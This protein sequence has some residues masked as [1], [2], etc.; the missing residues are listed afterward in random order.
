M[1]RAVCTQCGNRFV[2]R[3]DQDWKVLCLSCWKARA[4]SGQ[5][6][7]SPLLATVVA[8][9]ERLRKQLACMRAELAGALATRVPSKATIPGAMLK[10]LTHLCH[11]DRHCGSVAATKATQ[12]LLAQRGQP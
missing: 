2:R 9:N 6:S 8:E 3:A 1:T 4:A 10:R 5:K 7:K 12:W 11:P